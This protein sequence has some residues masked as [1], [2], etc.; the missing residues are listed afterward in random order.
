M[1]F[2]VTIER[3]EET[4]EEHKIII[5]NDQNSTASLQ[6]LVNKI[7]K[8]A[9]K[10][11]AEPITMNISKP[12]IKEFTVPSAYATHDIKAT[13]NGDMG[14]VKHIVRDVVINY[15]IIK[16]K[17]GWKILGSV[18]KTDSKWNIINGKI[19]NIGDLK[20]YDL[21]WCDHCNKKRNRKKVLVLED[22][23]GNR[24]IVGRQCVKDYLGIS[25]Q[26]AIFAADFSNYISGL[27]SPLSIPES[28]DEEDFENCF[29]LKK[30][31]EIELLARA[32]VA[33]MEKDK[34]AYRSCKYSDWSTPDAV[35]HIIQEHKNGYSYESGSKIRFHI[36]DFVTENSEKITKE[37]LEELRTEYPEE[38]IDRLD[39]SF[40]YDLA[41][42]IN[43]GHTKQE[44][45]FIGMLG[46]RIGKRMEAKKVKK[47]NPENSE[48][49]G[50][51]GDKIKDV[52]VEIAKHRWCKTSW[53]DSL[54]ICGFFKGTDNQ[55]TAFLSGK[56]DWLFED[57]DRIKGEVT[58]SATI[59]DHQDRGY[60][61][62][63]VLT[64]IKL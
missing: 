57:D 22:A 20:Q 4:M 10:Y 8:K 50:S 3:K 30:F 53:G 61:K 16:I 32:T 5:L 29:T 24:K 27:F 46:Y 56:T 54:M 55:F 38:F 62:Q 21:A 2:R 7:N 12:Y 18:E 35:Q 51:I 14:K 42:M 26:H 45:Y 59:K 39:N 36:D 13:T 58:I 37:V 25:I 63:T 49:Y 44:K 64:R 11:G 17:G 48:Y 40:E 15:E 23:D 43:L 52:E 47:H 34:W 28:D 33:V 9:Q 1:K 6:K 41:V 31:T 19:E 60:G